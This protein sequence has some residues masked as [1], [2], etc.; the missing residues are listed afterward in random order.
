[1][2]IN[3]ETEFKTFLNHVVSTIHGKYSVKSVEVAPITEDGSDLAAQP[4]KIYTDLVVMS[5]GW[6]PIVNLFSQ[7]G[8]KLEWDESNSFFK[9][10]QYLQSCLCIGGSNGNFDM[11][12]CIDKTI[13][14]SNLILRRI[15]K[16]KKS[17]I[18]FKA[19]Y[20]NVD[21][22]PRNIWHIPNGRIL[23]KGGESIY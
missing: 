17:K 14:Q 12:E 2:I 7:S 1:M 11:Q 20:L 16:K 23:G 5:G 21:Y 8:G 22:K 15:G 10:S 18:A 9:P 19:S 6:T 3:R 4:F 13:S